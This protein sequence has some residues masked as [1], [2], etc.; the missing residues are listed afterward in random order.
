[1]L[2]TITGILTCVGKYSYITSYQLCAHNCFYFR[3]AKIKS[4]FLIKIHFVNRRAGTA[5]WKGKA[6]TGREPSKQRLGILQ[7]RCPSG[8]WRS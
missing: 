5:K 6:K 8:G 4:T 1:M 3:A 7:G 2:L